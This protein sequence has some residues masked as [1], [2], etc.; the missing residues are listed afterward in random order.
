MI[1]KILHFVWLGSV[2]PDEEKKYI[3]SWKKYNPDFHI[4]I[5]NDENFLDLNISEPSLKAIKA[6]EGIYAYQADIIRY[7]AIYKYGGFYIDTDIECHKPIPHSFLNFEMIFLRPRNEINWITNA[8]FGALPNNLFFK[9][10][11]ENI[12]PKPVNTVKK[13]KGYL[14]G[15]SFFTNILYIFLKKSKSE[16]VLNLS[17][18]QIH[19]LDYDFWSPKNKNRN[20]THFFKA[21]WLK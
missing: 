19:V 7:H 16:K 8:F 5:W 13:L 10:L 21:S 15:P 3:N 2:I 1:P 20:C 14:F 12:T 18:K 11:I 4:M 9:I 17:N 6:G